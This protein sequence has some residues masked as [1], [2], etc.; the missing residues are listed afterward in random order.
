LPDD[1]IERFADG[2]VMAMRGYEVDQVRTTDDGREVSVPITWAYNHHYIAWLLD[3]TAVRVVERP[4]TDRTVRM[5]H[6]ND[7]VWVVEDRTDMDDGLGRYPSSQ[8]ISEGNGGEMRKSWHNYP[9]GYAQLIRS[10]NAF[11]LVP[12]Q[13]DTWNRNMTNATFLPGPIP[14][15]SRIRDGEAGY[16]PILEC[17]CSDRLEKVWGMT[18]TLDPKSCTGGPMDN[19]TECF[20]AAQ[21][22]LPS[23]QVVTDDVQDPST[24]EGCTA[25]MEDGG[26][27]HVVWNS[28]RP[29]NQTS[30]TTTDR[31]GGDGKLVGVANG[32]VN[33][34]VTMDAGTNTVSMTLRGPADRWFGVGFGADSMCIR[35]EADECPTQG[36]YAVIVQGDHVEERKL[37]YHGP[38]VVLE[39][40]VSI[41]SNTVEGSTRLVRLNRTLSGQTERHYTFDPTQRTMKVIM[42]NGCSLGFAQHCGH[43]SNQVNFVSAGSVQA[44][45]RAGVHGSIDGNP[46]HNNCLPYPQSVLLEQNNPTCSI[47]TYVGKSVRYGGVVI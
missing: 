16:N 20:D 46:F 35:M 33:I 15:S 30:R 25:T 12:M 27:L 10:P 26:V 47:E 2:K 28:Y 37:D 14:R 23:I 7:R 5:S 13:I 44:V 36:P 34:T 11:H 6:G 43:Q 24:P 45:C 8:F 4:V 22:L 19:A 32:L 9:K 41:E 21:R 31:V 1:I 42:A 3:T 40:T 39:S 29:H 17:P 18:Y 38:G